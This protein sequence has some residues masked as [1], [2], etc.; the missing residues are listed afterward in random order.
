V[1]A[2]V[3]RVRNAVRAFPWL[4]TAAAVGVALYLL[5]CAKGLA[6]VGELA[7]WQLIVPRAIALL[8]ICVFLT[9]RYPLI[10]PFGLYVALVPFDALLAVSGGATLVR[11][12]GF[13]AAGALAL[14]TLVLRRALVPGPSWYPWVALVAYAALTLMWTPEFGKGVNTFSTML[15]LLLM[16]TVLATYP[17]GKLEFKITMALTV[18]AGVGAAVF[19]LHQYYSGHVTLDVN[20]QG[21]RLALQGFSS[22]NIEDPNFLAGAFLVA[23][24]LALAG[25]LYARGVAVRIA[26]A[27]AIPPMIAAVLVTGSRSA[28]FAAVALFAYFAIRS[29]HRLGALALGAFGLVAITALYPSVLARLFDKTFVNG[30]GR[31]DIWQ[32]GLHSFSDHWLFGAGVESYQY[33]YDRNLLQVFQPE[34]AGWTRPGHSLVFVSLNDFGVIGFALVLVCWYVGFRQLSVIP[35]TSWLYG[36]RLGLE[37]GM[38]ALFIHM[39]FLD[40]FYIK[41]VWLGQSLPLIALNLYAPRTLRAGRRIGVPIPRMRPA[42][43]LRGT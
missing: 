28:F 27:L 7:G 19:T 35:K 40:P 30:S 20:S 29:K 13:A 41:Y 22:S 1:N 23:L 38:L 33:I 11:L 25:V 4:K 14:R 9:F 34:F 10:F 17:V 32:T 31:T 12:I 26:C 42:Q 15:M 8:P 18:L 21:H 43:P 3:R 6:S 24:G 16:M 5:A 2:I 37:A 36:T 39:L